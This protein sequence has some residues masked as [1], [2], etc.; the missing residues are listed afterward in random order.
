MAKLSSGRPCEV[1]RDDDDTRAHEQLVTIA[2]V[3]GQVRLDDG[4]RGTNAQQPILA[5]HD[6]WHVSSGAD[7][8]DRERQSECAHGGFDGRDSISVGRCSRVPHSAINLPALAFVAVPRATDL[9]LELI[10]Q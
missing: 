10:V 4:K 9:R 5:D 6:S 8:G 7:Y 3:A 1:L 2:W